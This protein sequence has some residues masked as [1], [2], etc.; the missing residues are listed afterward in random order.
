MARPKL[1]A[2][3]CLGLGSCARG[4]AEAR[5]D[6][7]SSA[8][9]H[10]S[11]AAAACRHPARLSVSALE[12]AGYTAGQ[13]PLGMRPAW[14][15]AGIPLFVQSAAARTDP[16]A[17][18]GEADRDPAPALEHRDWP[19]SLPA[20]FDR[21]AAAAAAASS[22]QHVATASTRR[23]SRAR[24]RRRRRHDGGSG[25]FIGGTVAVAARKPYRPST[26]YSYIQ[27][28]DRSSAPVP[29]DVL[30]RVRG[31]TCRVRARRGGATP[32]T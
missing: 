32:G 8:C 22:R 26:C 30:A 27:A 5:F 31:D 1:S 3:A 2:A 19:A 10:G 15:R 4:Q 14:A 9:P 17:T 16:A 29:T 18:P 21:A 11:E 25:G 13:T 6:V 12:R 20:A 7:P 28:A 24:R 23:T